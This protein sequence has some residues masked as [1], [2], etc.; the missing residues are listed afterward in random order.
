MLRGVKIQ[1]LKGRNKKK[2]KVGCINLIQPPYLKSVNFLQ[3]P[4]SKNTKGY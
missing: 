2:K 4:A 3:D 1:D